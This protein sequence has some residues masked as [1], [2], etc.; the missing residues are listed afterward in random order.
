MV[1]KIEYY[2]GDTLLYGKV[3]DFVVSIAGQNLTLTK[4]QI[5]LMIGIFKDCVK[6]IIKEI[7]MGEWINSDL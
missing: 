4:K 6:I 7:F 1:I 5:T 3:N 2:K